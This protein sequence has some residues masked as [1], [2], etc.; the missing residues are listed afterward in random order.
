MN[1]L[2]NIKIWKRTG[3]GTTWAPGT[4]SGGPNTTFIDM[5]NWGGCMFLLV[6]ASTVGP[7]TGTVF[8]R[9]TTGQSTAG[10][11]ALGSSY[12]I[13]L[14]STNR[15]AALDFYRP[16]HRYVQLKTL[17]CTGIIV[18]PITYGGR[19]VGSTEDWVYI[20]PTSG[21]AVTQLVLGTT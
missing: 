12:K 6:A 10:G 1:L 7:S 11:K 16:T 2:N 8:L 13:I 14:G 19:R 18:V 17:T 4:A 20:K 3:G 9:Q 15:V 21:Q 5:S